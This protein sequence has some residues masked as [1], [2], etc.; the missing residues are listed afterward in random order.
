MKMFRPLV[1]GLLLLATPVAWSQKRAKPPASQPVDPDF[2]AIEDVAGL[3]RVLLIGDSV[4]IGYTP[5]TRRLLAGLANVHRI[6][7]NGEATVDGLAN[8]DRWLATG[9]TGKKWDVIHFNWGLH[10]LRQY[11]EGPLIPG[12]P[13]AVPLPDYERNLRTLV[14]RLKKTGA[15][16]IFATTTPVPPGN[17]GRQPGLE[18]QYNEAALRV[19]KEEGVAVDDLYSA[20][21]AHRLDWQNLDEVHFNE[22]GS[23]AL[24]ALV[25]AAI[26][27]ALQK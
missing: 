19:M 1:F 7:A 6:P 23:R 24:A 21:M 8:L 9:G 22:Q 11:E 13:V 15:K 25:A 27:S 12:A 10:D 14:A 3:P 26:K 4:S 2:A 17:V 20:A 16:L 18:I 5:P